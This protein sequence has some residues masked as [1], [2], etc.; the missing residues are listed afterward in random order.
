MVD[1]CLGSIELYFKAASHTAGESRLLFLYTITNIWP[2]FEMPTTSYCTYLQQSIKRNL[3]PMTYTQPDRIR[4][5][6]QS[7]KFVRNE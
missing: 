3:I 7:A 4:G 1:L 6:P 2:E 5:D